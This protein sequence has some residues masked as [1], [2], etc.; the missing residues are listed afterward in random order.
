LIIRRAA[1][2]RRIGLLVVLATIL[3]GCVA[4]DMGR[5][6]TG[7]VALEMS[8]TLVD[9][10]GRGS[11][12][13]TSYVNSTDSLTASFVMVVSEGSLM[14]HPWAAFT[15]FTPGGQIVQVGEEPLIFVGANT[16]VSQCTIQANL[17]SFPPEIRPYT[18]SVSVGEHSKSMDFHV[19]ASVERVTYR[20]N[21]ADQE[22]GRLPE[23]WILEAPGYGPDAQWIESIVFEN[24]N[25]VLRMTSYEER[26][27]ILTRNINL[28]H[29]HIELNLRARLWEEAPYEGPNDQALAF[30]F[31]TQTGL[32]PVLVLG[33]SDRQQVLPFGDGY[34][35]NGWVEYKIYVDLGHDF[36][37]ASIYMDCT[38]L[39]SRQ[40]PPLG[41]QDITGI[42]ITLGDGAYYV[43]QFDDIL[44]QEY[45]LENGFP[46]HP[47]EAGIGVRPSHGQWF[48][49]SSI[50]TS[51]SVNVTPCLASNP[52]IL[53]DELNFELWNRTHMLGQFGKTGWNGTN[54]FDSPC[55]VFNHKYSHRIPTDLF[56]GPGEYIVV[57]R[58]ADP[59]L[60]NLVQSAAF[61]IDEPV[62]A[63]FSVIEAGPP[64]EP[65][66]FDMANTYNISI[67]VEFDPAPANGGNTNFTD[68]NCKISWADPEGEIIKNDSARMT[69][70]KS[71]PSVKSWVFGNLRVRSSY[72]GGDYA[73]S[74]DALCNSG[75]RLQDTFG[76]TIIGIGE[77]PNTFALSVFLCLLAGSSLRRR[78]WKT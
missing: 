22:P 67:G 60:T 10:D 63:Y 46:D 5:G 70:K 76:F 57:S 47:A 12:F 8:L 52:Y 66:V 58:P 30:G 31:R 45:N 17:S 3:L 40:L 44:I 19:C 33:R 28:S 78:A 23:E 20:E 53:V 72:T 48:D 16:F 73:A 7:I 64:V 56:Q 54:F 59:S 18:L 25:R 77:T 68:K 2:L 34:P 32:E 41:V 39:G 74:I 6:G 42:S 61:H 9:Q 4:V 21:F 1:D 26:E 14:P 50:I 37:S 29:K 55:R 27:A 36:T 49:P 11:P 24:H 35:Q 62:Y 43:G 75:Y 51:Y 13:I 15:W 71:Y 69:W 65:P 38:R